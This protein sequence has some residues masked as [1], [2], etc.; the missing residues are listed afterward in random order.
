MR[1]AD[2]AADFFKCVRTI[3]LDPLTEFRYWHMS[4]PLE[5][6]M[7]PAVPCCNLRRL[8]RTVAEDLP[9]PPTLLGPW[10]LN[11][12]RSRVCHR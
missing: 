8:H 10:K 4:W 1:A 11:F 2:G 6:Q 7:H 12:G 3:T 5:H 9:A